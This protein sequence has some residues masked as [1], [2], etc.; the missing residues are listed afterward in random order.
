MLSYVRCN[1]AYEK[2]IR[3]TETA[4]N[5]MMPSSIK[6]IVRRGRT[7]IADSVVI[8]TSDNK[9][10]RIKPLLITN[11]LVNNSI[12][13]SIRLLTRNTLIRFVNKLTYEQV[14]EEI[15]SFKMQKHLGKTAAKIAPIRN[16]EIRG[17]KLVE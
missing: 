7:K 13:N 17:F 12:A 16:S 8:A 2:A 15:M 14:V 10:V 11:I 6:R 1:F 3:P 5:K 4:P 9:K